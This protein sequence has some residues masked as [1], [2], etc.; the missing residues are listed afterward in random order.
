MLDEALSFETF[1]IVKQGAVNRNIKHS[2]KKQFVVVKED[3][4]YQ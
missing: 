4:F 3:C 2:F 1:F